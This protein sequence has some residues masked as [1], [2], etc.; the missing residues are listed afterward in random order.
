MKPNPTPWWWR[1]T[2]WHLRIAGALVGFL[3]LIALVWCEMEGSYGLALVN[4]VVVGAMIMSAYI[5][6]VIFEP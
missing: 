3:A 6:W 1:R 5:E 2:T 4:A